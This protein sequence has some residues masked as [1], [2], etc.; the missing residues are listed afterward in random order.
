VLYKA[1]MRAG[2]AALK[3]TGQDDPHRAGYGFLSNL[4]VTGKGTWDIGLL[5][6]G[7]RLTT[8]SSRGV[9]DLH[10]Q[11]LNVARATR[12]SAS[13]L[14]RGVTHF[15]WFGGQIMPAGVTNRTGLMV[16]GLPG[17][18][19][20]SSNIHIFGVNVNGDLTF[21]RASTF[22]F[23]GCVGQD[24][25][26]T[27]YCNAGMV[28]GVLLGSIKNEGTAVTVEDHSGRVSGGVR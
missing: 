8:P 23:F 14:L 24:L 7:S 18:N 25:A 19:H 3:F 28:K 16:A 5:V 27:K 1:E 6:D 10:I 21:D 12:P 2:G 22:L 15:Y 17:A 26:I 20:Q 9:R 4:L 11:N 13:V